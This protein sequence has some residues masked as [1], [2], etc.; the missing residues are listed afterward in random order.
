MVFIYLSYLISDSYFVK[1]FGFS[2]VAGLQSS[3]V[4]KQMREELEP[5]MMKHFVDVA[6]WGHEHHY[7]RTCPVYQGQCYGTLESPGRTWK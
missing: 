6:L 3:N 7:E 1:R 2:S 4:A 5:L